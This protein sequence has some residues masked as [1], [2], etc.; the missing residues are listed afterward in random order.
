M[1]F[2]MWIDAIDL[3][4]FYGTALGRIA[5]RI[6]GRRIRAVWPDVRGMRVLGLGYATP[7]LAPFRGEAERVLALMP[8]RQGVVRWPADEPGLTALA[9]EAHL[10]FPDRSFDRI[11]VVHAL[12]CTEQTQP[13]MRELWRVLAD[14]GHLL[15]VAP[16]RRG[17]W[18]R[19]ERTPFGHGRPY[20][21]GQLSRFLQEAMF[22][23]QRS[24]VA[25]FVPPVDSRML[26]SM[27]PAWEEIG[28]RWFTNFA[29]VVMCEATKQIYAGQSAVAETRRA[30]YVAP[31]SG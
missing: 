24:A 10:P 13:M 9:G 20:S 12:E 8:S 11:L 23:S 15:V 2:S 7:F 18:C 29:G 30:A 27:A 22:L 21:A 16:N 19:F 14:G 4:D 6:I 5:R 25:L 1:T 28:Q 31:V 26:L 3:R 17:L